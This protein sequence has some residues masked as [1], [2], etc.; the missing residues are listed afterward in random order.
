MRLIA[1]RA[2]GSV[3]DSM[4]LLDQT[5][6]LGGDNLTSAVTREVLG[7]AGQELFA[8]LFDALHARD[9]A[10]VSQLCASLFRQGWTSDF[11][12]ASWPDICATCSC[13]GRAARPWR[14][15]WAC[16]ARRSFSAGPGPAFLRRS[17]A[18][19]LADGT[20]RPARHRAESRAGRSLELLLL[21]LALLPQLLPL[22]RMDS[23][24]APSAPVQGHPAHDRQEGS[25]LPPRDMG[26]AVPGPG[27]GDPRP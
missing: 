12:C 10:A 4:S 23:V 2:A 22:E 14:P 24:P 8:D 13:C 15:L 21:N 17:P 1:R 20:G 19:G 18:R 27:P 5:L 26:H 6:A 7:L 11:S 3:R 16:P 9:C 25:P